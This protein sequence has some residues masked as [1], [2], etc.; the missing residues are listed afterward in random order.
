MAGGHGYDVLPLTNFDKTTR[1]ESD[2]GEELVRQLVVAGNDAAEVHQL[3]EEPLDQ[4]ALTVERLAEAVFP[5][6]VALWR[7]IG[8][9]ALFLDQCANAV[10]VVDLV[11]QYDNVRPR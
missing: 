4:V 5:A 8:R 9:R 2:H 11:S 3:R 1:S 7:D 6:S 10:G